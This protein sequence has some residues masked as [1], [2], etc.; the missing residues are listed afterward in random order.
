MQFYKYK[1]IVAKFMC[2]F[3]GCDYCVLLTMNMLWHVEFMFN[4]ILNLLE[5]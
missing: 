4:Q 1:Y 3:V 5:R 2:E